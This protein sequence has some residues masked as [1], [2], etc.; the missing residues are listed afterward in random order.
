MT[1]APERTQHVIDG[2]N[3]ADVAV[4]VAAHR[5][6]GGLDPV[7]VLGFADLAGALHQLLGR[8]AAWTHQVA[9]QVASL[10]THHELREDTGTVDPAAR[11]YQAADHLTQVVSTHLAA[12]QAAAQEFHAAIAHLAQQDDD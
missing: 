2:L 1:H 4:R 6:G 10:P 9:P 3:A 7:G 8:L 5:G 11:C 12:A